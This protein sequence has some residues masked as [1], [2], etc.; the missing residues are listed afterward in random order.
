[1][2]G[3]DGVDDE[4]EILRQFLHRRFVFRDHH[5]MRAET[6]GVR[7]FP[8]GSSEQSDMSAKRVRELERHVSEATKS[9]YA[10]FLTAADL[11]FSQR[12]IRRDPR[13]LKRRSRR[14]IE[15][16]RAHL[17]FIVES[18]EDAIVGKTLVGV[19]T[20][21]NRAAERL[22]G[23]TAGEIIGQSAVMLVPPDRPQ[24]WQKTLELMRRGEPIESFETVGL[25]KDGQPIDVA[26][27]ISP[28]KDATGQ[29]VGASTVARDVTQ[30]KREEQERL[31]LIQE[32]QDALKQV[33]TLSGLLPICAS[34]KKIRDDNGYWQQVETY[35]QKHSNADFTHGICPE[36]LQRLY[37]KYNEAV[38]SV[39]TSATAQPQA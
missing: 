19:V 8:R 34:C 23:Y 16:A 29:V 32:L 15:A 7:C 21:W 36:C 30:R 27:T 4:I 35:I 13:A 39:P 14:Q 2:S 38:D 6:F 33:K 28:I 18:C 22:Y 26:L 9:D 11:P 3:R 31:K 17:A 24:D 20:S 12:R 37:P 10:N 5:F 25:R 1:M